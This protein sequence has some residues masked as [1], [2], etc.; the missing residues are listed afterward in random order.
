MTALNAATGAYIWNYT[1]G[2]SNSSP[3][4]AEGVLYIISDDGYV[5]AFG[6]MAAPITSA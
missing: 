5:H 4:I 1:T 3:A 6:L 2:G